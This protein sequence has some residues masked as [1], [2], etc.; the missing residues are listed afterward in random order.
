M[1]GDEPN[2]LERLPISCGGVGGFVMEIPMGFMKMGF[3]FVWSS[4]PS[5]CFFSVFY[6]VKPVFIFS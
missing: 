5:W 3:F 1:A 4:F 6:S 2:E